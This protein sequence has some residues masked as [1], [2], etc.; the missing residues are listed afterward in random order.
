VYQVK[1]RF[2]KVC[3]KVESPQPIFLKFPIGSEEP[4]QLKQAQ[5]EIL[6]NNLFYYEIDDDGIAKK[7]QFVKKWAKDV[8]IR[9]Y[10]RTVVDPQMLCPATDYNMWR[11]FAAD[12]LPPVADELID[13]MM[14]PIIRHLNDVITLGNAEHTGY[15][16]DYLAN[17]I[18][19]PHKKTQVAIS[20]FG[21]QGAGKGIIFDFFRTRVLGKHCSFQTS[22]VDNDLLGN[23]AN[24]FFNKVFVQV[25]AAW[26][27][28]AAIV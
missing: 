25:R 7:Y 22:N 18:Q 8:T 27:R 26:R 5:L 3:F 28:Q 23:F 1:A 11:G 15:I 4:D 19:R 9:T 17:I 14:A 6:H 12:K 16:L 24:G 20:L 2:E 10:T 21:A 13:D